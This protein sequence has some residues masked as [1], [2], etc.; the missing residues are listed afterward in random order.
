MEETEFQKVEDAETER[1]AA[2]AERL[3]HSA[4]DGLLGKAQVDYM[5]GLLQSAP[6]LREQA[7]HGY[8]Y[9]FIRGGGHT[10]GFCG[11]QMQGEK[12]F[13]SK[14][15]LCDE[16][17]GRGVGQLAL[18]KVVSIA[19]ERGAKSVYLT[20]NKGNARAVRA[21]EK[22]GFARTSEQVSDIGGGYV[23]DDYIYEYAL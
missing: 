1:L 22:F 20:V 9:Y 5:V 16:F 2:L 3:W 14:L 17:R 19:R 11:V 8:T 4:Y 18:A 6:A 15:Y 12:L 10:L 21:Y 7:A 23:M 13:L